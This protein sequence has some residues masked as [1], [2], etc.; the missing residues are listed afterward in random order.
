MDILV[1]GA[2][3][4]TGRLLVQQLL[5]RGQ[6]I[7]VVVRSTDKLPEALRNHNLLTTVQAGILDLSAEEMIQ[8]VDG[9]AAV[10]SCCF[11]C[12][13]HLT[14]TTRT[15]QTTCAPPS[16]GPMRRYN[17]LQSDRTA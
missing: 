15:P 10:A 14:Q 16:A 8:Q 5:D 7:R 17:G 11:A 12:C 13:C 2:T 1:V 6:K 4:A 3:G 9:C